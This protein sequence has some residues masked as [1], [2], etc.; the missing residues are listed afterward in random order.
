VDVTALDSR[1]LTSSSGRMTVAV[2]SAPDEFGDKTV[3]DTYDIQGR[4]DREK[5]ARTQFF[6]TGDSPATWFNN[7]GKSSDKV[8]SDRRKQFS[9]PLAEKAREL[10]QD[11]T[12]MLKEVQSFKNAMLAS[13]GAV[14]WLR[15]N[16]LDLLLS[17]LGAARLEGNQDYV[18]LKAAADRHQSGLSRKEGKAWG[19][20]RI[21]NADAIEYK[22][23]VA[24]MG[25]SVSLNRVLLEDYEKKLRNDIRTGLK[26]IGVANFDKVTIE[27]AIKD[28]ADISGITPKNNFY[29]PYFKN[30]FALSNQPMPR[31]S[32]EYIQGLRTQGDLDRKLYR[33]SYLVPIVDAN[34]DLIP[35]KAADT[36][37]KADLYALRDSN[38]P[39]KRAAF[40]KKSK[41]INFLWTESYGALQ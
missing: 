25:K 10:I 14:G 1:D 7:L 8:M 24:A 32:A 41:L 23:M 17:T 18:R 20:M 15:G 9:G 12:N 28:G 3:D 11:S 2:N 6:N 34:G 27:N 19:D 13:K 33:G 31:H 21:S 5:A 37:T 4:A 29:S 39:K 30:K 16:V 38:D 22:K 35:G 40:E 26:Q 36:I